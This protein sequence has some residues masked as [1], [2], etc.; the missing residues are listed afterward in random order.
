MEMKNIRQSIL[1]NIHGVG[2]TADVTLKPEQV[3]NEILKEKKAGSFTFNDKDKK[4]IDDVHIDGV[5]VNDSGKK[6]T[7]GSVGAGKDGKENI[8]IP[9]ATYLSEDKGTKVSYSGVEITP[10]VISYEDDVLKMLNKN[11]LLKGLKGA[12]LKK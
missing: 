7:I 6:Q 4:S 3:I 1:E 2:V 12:I 11:I 10:A 5:Y 9:G 8:V